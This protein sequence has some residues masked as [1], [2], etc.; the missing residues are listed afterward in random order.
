VLLGGRG[1]GPDTVAPVRSAVFDDLLRGSAIYGVRVYSNVS[2]NSALLS[3]SRV[4]LTTGQ[5]VSSCSFASR[6][7]R[8]AA[9]TAWWGAARS[10]VFAVVALGH[11][12]AKGGLAPRL[13]GYS[14]MSE[15]PPSRRSR[16]P[17][18]NR[19]PKAL[20]FPHWR[21]AEFSSI[22][23]STLSPGIPSLSPSREVASP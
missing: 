12:A 13:C 2:S 3:L 10:N 7:E 18:R 8:G 11:L 4:C 1:T 17:S 5:F 15:P 23:I 6:A 22:V 14:T 21:S 20:G 19:E 16:P 9:P